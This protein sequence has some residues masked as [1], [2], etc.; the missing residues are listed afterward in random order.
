MQF[1]QGES[2]NPNEKAIKLAL[3]GNE[4]MLRLYLERT[5]RHQRGKIR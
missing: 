1:Q 3:A 4:A 2:G 5:H